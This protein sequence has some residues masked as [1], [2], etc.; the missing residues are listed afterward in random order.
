MS[1]RLLL[2]AVSERPRQLIDLVISYRS[3]VGPPG[4]VSITGLRGMNRSNPRP[5]R[6]STDQIIY[7]DFVSY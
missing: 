2:R 3:N 1:T 7:I 4:T 6:A 5:D